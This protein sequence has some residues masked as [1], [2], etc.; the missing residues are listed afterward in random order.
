M[1]GTREGSLAAVPASRAVREGCADATSLVDRAKQGDAEAFGDLMRLYEGRIIAIGIQMGLS[2]DD[3]MDACQDAFIKVFRYIR[4]FR[5]GEVFFRWLYRIA[6]NCIYDHQRHARPGWVVSIEE[7]V[8][9]GV[10]ALEDGSL[11]PGVRAENADLV[12]KLLREVR[13]LTKRERIVFVLRDLQEMPTQDIAKA[14]GL[15][16]VTV[17]RHCMSARHKLRDRVFPR[18]T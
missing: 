6:L 18:Q 12:A 7:V 4:H 11:H 16:E 17:R 15:T 1:D 13:H 2:R 3:S 5:S 10:T 14:L 9:A 8:G